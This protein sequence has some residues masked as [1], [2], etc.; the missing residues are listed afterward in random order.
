MAP[1]PSQ[2]QSPAVSSGSRNLV[3]VVID[4][5]RRDR[6]GVY[7]DGDSL[8]PNIDA[9]A[10]G[11][12]TFENAFTCT[13]A[14]DPSV[15]S[16]HTGRDPESVVTHHGPF[17]T[18]AEKRRA[19]SVRT[20]PELLQEAG[21]HTAVT[22]RTL[23]RWHSRGFD[24]YPETSLDRYRRRAIGER[25]GSISPRL[26][27]FAGAVYERASALVSSSTDEIDR[28][29]DVID[30]G[31]SYGFVHMMDTHVPYSY[32]EGVVEDRLATGS[33]P[34]Q[35][36]EE[37]FSAHAANPYVA[38]TMRE[39]SEPADY[40]AGL[41]RWYA[42]YDAAV[43]RADRKVGK[44][45]DRLRARG[46]F[47]DTTVVVTSDHG[48]SLDEHGIFFE[49][50][51]LYEPQV[52]VPL[53]VGGPAIPTQRRDE[54]VQLYDLAPT[55]LDVL[56]VDATLDCDGRS[57]APLLGRSGDWG[58]REHVV[59]QEAHA[60]RRIGVRSDR[61][62]FLKH[63][64]DEVLERERGDSFRCGYCETVHGDRRELYDL[65]ADP[66]ESENIVEAAPDRAAALEDAAS[67]YFDSLTDPGADAALDQDETVEYEDEQAVLDRL[68]D[69]GYR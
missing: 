42:K 35:D 48:E 36:L 55:T 40:R 30:D 21:I 53:V 20:V 3:V 18:E 38:E 46:L 56:G 8:T 44:L 33:Y 27:Q 7:S 34:S 67:T 24:H 9:L 19:A 54:L 63:E 47:E 26:R 4:A 43:V 16:I 45:V 41:A 23:G 6:V 1:G 68:E 5:L 59:I 58:D 17:V 13:N 25:L 49:H 11:G 28:L 66:G 12:T 61:Y 39:Y 10:A 37:F 29:L 65:E 15:T 60:Q 14:T 51:G 50:H 57:L 2:A 31:S 62:K 64:C 22:G 69:L 32:D 52:R